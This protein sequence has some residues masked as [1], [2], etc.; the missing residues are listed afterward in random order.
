MN[1]VPVKWLEELLLLSSSTHW[2]GQVLLSPE[3]SGC[4][5]IYTHG[6]E[7]EF[8]AFKYKFMFLPSAFHGASPHNLQ[9]PGGET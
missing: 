9:F 7:M 8:S 1:S 5:L 3:S 2:Q 6:F 4:T